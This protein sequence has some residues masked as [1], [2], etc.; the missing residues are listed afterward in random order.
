MI[1]FNEQHEKEDEDEDDF[2]EDHD[3][4]PHSVASQVCHMTC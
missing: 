2:L 3:Q 4:R 1:T